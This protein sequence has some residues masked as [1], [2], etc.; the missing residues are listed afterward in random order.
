MICKSIDSMVIVAVKPG[1]AGMRKA[2]EALRPEVE[3]K[4][5]AGLEP[6]FQAKRDVM[7]KM[8]SAVMSVIEPLLKEHVTPH[9]GKI[10]SIIKSPVRSNT[11]NFLG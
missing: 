11:V 1:W 10:V 9:L 3:P 4:I 2:V 7:D 8:R 5:R 6:I